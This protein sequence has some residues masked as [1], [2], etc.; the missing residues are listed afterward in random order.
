M[1]SNQQNV[2]VITNTQKSQNWYASLHVLTYRLT[3]TLTVYTL[4]KK[5]RLGLK[6]IRKEIN[7]FI[8]INNKH[9]L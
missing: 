2:L 1:I 8:K 5:N 7:Q 9:Q 6:I 3:E 4:M